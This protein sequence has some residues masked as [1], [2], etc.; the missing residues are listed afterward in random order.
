MVATKTS[1][2]ASKSKS[3]LQQVSS[4]SE[5]VA[6]FSFELIESSE[7]I[8]QFFFG[9]WLAEERR[10]GLRQLGPLGIAAQRP[11]RRVAQT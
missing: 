9:F 5:L 8:F 6:D 1:Q 3:H 4:V 2:P 10:G 7:E 11:S